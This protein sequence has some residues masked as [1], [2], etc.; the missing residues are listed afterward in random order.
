MV[1]EIRIV[2]APW[3][4]FGS[5]G[6]I[7]DLNSATLIAFTVEASRLEHLNMGRY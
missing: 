3:L 6:E 7:A 4:S 5:H 2:P 1:F